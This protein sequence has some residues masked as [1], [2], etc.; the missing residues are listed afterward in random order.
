MY[1][2]SR[3]RSN[4]RFTSLSRGALS[5]TFVF[6]LIEFFDEFV[7]AVG[8]AARPSLRADL[9]LSYTQIGILLGLP[10]ALNTLLEPA[11]MLLG[12]TRYRKH[13]VIAGGLGMALAAALVA[14][15]HSFTALL[16]AEIISFP[17]S[18]AFVTL[19]QATLMDLNPG[20]EPHMMARWSASGALANLIAPLILAGGF[21][22]A[23]GW[24][25]MYAALAV[26]GLVLALVTVFRPFPVHPHAVSSA[27]DESGGTLWV[28]RTL[29]R[30]LW[31]T[32]HNLNLLRWLALLEMSDL[33]LDMFSG[34]VA[35]YFADVMGL[36]AVQ[37]SLA[38]SLLMLVSLVS[39]LATIP[40]LERFSGR[41]IVRFTAAWAVL[42]YTAFLLASWTLVKIGLA[43]LVRLSTLGWYPVLEGEAYAAAQGR[44]GTMKAVQSLGGLAAGAIAGLIGWVAGLAGLQTAMGLLL[45]GPLCLVA[46]VPRPAL[47]Q[48]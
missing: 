39:D 16:L 28:L 8:G 7:Y 27:T 37:T 1:P 35:L 26:W 33:L 21:A 11:V 43:L 40:L 19:S 32:I 3:F 38:L 12:D 41:A 47:E 36:D 13:L 45:F 5:L 22:L 48:G 4:S 46:F 20:R 30:N 2:F 24:R 17:S 9:G 44:S 23:L 31:V 42:A 15:A 34:Y 6:L 29:F 25:W 18:G 10:A 14:G